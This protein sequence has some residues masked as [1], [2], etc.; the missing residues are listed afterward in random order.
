MSNLQDVL[1]HATNCHCFLILQS[2]FHF[3]SFSLSPVSPRTTFPQYLDKRDRSPSSH[4]VSLS[5]RSSWFPLILLISSR[6]DLT[7][8]QSVHLIPQ[9]PSE[10]YINITTQISKVIKP[11]SRSGAHQ[12]CVVITFQFTR[13]CHT[14]TCTSQM[15][16][17]VVFLTS[18]IIIAVLWVYTTW[19]AWGTCWKQG[20]FFSFCVLCSVLFRVFVFIVFNNL[21]HFRPS[22]SPPQSPSIQRHR[23]REL[24]TRYIQKKATYW[25]RVITTVGVGGLE[26]R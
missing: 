2:F 12:P 18:I 7:F 14:D 20:V 10:A 19:T 17:Y 8:H 24:Q 6:P 21:S 26:L 11:T 23:K 22:I 1:F 3:I 15:T 5:G 13:S 25:G 16:L 4:H 9:I